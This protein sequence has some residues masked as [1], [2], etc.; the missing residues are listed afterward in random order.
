MDAQQQQPD[1]V[2]HS[3]IGDES[4]DLDEQDPK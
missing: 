3:V 2:S 1:H 4:A